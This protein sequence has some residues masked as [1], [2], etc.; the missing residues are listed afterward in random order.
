MCLFSPVRLSEPTTSATRRTRPS[1]IVR[2]P[3]IILKPHPIMFRP[4]IRP[5][6][7]VYH[8]SSPHSWEHFPP[9]SHVSARTQS[10]CCSLISSHKKVTRF[11]KQRCCSTPITKSSQGLPQSLNQSHESPKLKKKFSPL[12][13][14]A[15]G[16]AR[17]KVGVASGNISCGA[18]G[19]G[20]Q[21]D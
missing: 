8:S 17:W 9:S 3:P 6:P 1:R 10:V 14:C 21:V 16:S 19:V 5:I 13:D 4:P 18:G 7:L 20:A 11:S 12:V 2:N 15:T